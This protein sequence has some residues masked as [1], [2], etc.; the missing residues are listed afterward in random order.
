MPAESNSCRGQSCQKDHLPNQI[1]CRKCNQVD[2]VEYLCEK[3]DGI[4]VHASLFCEKHT[5]SSENRLD[6]LI[7]EVKSIKTMLERMSDHFDI[8]V[9]RLDLLEKQ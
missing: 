4:C 3:C 7:Q 2:S 1:F 9:S 8:L 5:N 6:E